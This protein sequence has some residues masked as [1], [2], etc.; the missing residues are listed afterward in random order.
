V[1]AA[2]ALP[3]CILIK[4]GLLI[5]AALPVLIVALPSIRSEREDALQA[6]CG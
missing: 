6:H 4:P 1:T 2:S 3:G 5:A